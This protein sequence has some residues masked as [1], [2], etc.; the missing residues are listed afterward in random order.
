MFSK[1]GLSYVQSRTTR[2]YEPRSEHWQYWVDIFCMIFVKAKARSEY[3]KTHEYR[4]ACADSENVVRG[5][6]TSKT[7]FFFYYFFFIL[8][9]ERGSKQIPL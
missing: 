9:G 2:S 6:P 3:L 4:E 1:I 5:G 8:R 7:F